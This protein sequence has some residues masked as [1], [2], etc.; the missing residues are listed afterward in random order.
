[1]EQFQI[2]TLSVE[3]EKKKRGCSSYPFLQF[4]QLLSVE[5][6]LLPQLLLSLLQL[7]SL[8]RKHTKNIRLELKT[9]LKIKNRKPEMKPH[10]FPQCLGSR[11][12]LPQKDKPNQI[13][14]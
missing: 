7:L 9:V 2:R 14:K 1:M 12:N 8:R 3:R 5:G 4:A 11:S 6:V 13:N 10:N